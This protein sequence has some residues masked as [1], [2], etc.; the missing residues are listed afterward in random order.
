MTLWTL[1]SIERDTSGH[2]NQIGR[3]TFVFDLEEFS[4]RALA[5]KPGNSLSVLFFTEYIFERKNSNAF[6]A[7][8][9]LLLQIQIYERNFPGNLRRVFVING[10]ILAFSQVLSADSN[11]A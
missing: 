2:S 7:L 5:Y 8:D 9:I 1:E 4:L 11:Y 3:A 10:N 6:S